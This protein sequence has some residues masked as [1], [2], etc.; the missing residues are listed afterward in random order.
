M[1]GW[2]IT[3]WYRVGT[4]FAVMWLGMLLAT[5]FDIKGEGWTVDDWIFLAVY[6]AA[7]V[8]LT[9]YLPRRAR[10]KRLVLRNMDGR[11]SYDPVTTELTLTV[12]VKA[13]QGE[14]ARSLFEPGTNYEL[15]GYVVGPADA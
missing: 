12:K 7:F 10:G 13:E 2:L 5:K 11:M 15:H 3:K 8:A 1:L 6:G 4:L 9:I 14:Q